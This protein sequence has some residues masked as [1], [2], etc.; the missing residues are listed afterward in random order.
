MVSSVPL[1]DGN[2]REFMRGLGYGFVAGYLELGNRF[3]HGHLRITL[4]RTFPLVQQTT[5]TTAA[6]QQTTM[7][8]T[9]PSP[10]IPISQILSVSQ[11]LSG[12]S[13]GGGGDG[14]GDDVLAGG[15]LQPLDRSGGYVLRVSARVSDG[16]KPELMNLAFAELAAFRDLLRGVVSLLPV[17]R[18]ALDTRVR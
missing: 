4:C 2:P 8:S 1:L 16:S 18:L 13:N 7:Q 3:T 10:E 15:M 9:E 12:S 5:T 6:A 14:G 11:A 17:E